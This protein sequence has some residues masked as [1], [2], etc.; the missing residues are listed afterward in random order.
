MLL[1]VAIGAAI[2]TGPASAQ[3]AGTSL[4][5]LAAQAIIAGC[6]VHSTARK[7]SHAVAVVDTGG[8]LVAALRM[9]GNGYGI[10]DFALA[11]AEAAAAW[12]FGTAQMAEGARDTPGF[13]DA[14]H[15]VTV[16]GGVPLWSADGKARIGAVG[17]S[18]EAPAD[19]AACAEAGIRAAGMRS[20][21]AN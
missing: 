1:V 17:V 5:P 14:P 21:R 10:M 15:V 2:S 11:K 6:V 3:Q 8:K 18:G 13:G 12:G 4:D 16:P 9:A 19:D 20:S 7:Q